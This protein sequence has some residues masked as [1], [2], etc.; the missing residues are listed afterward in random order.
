LKEDRLIENYSDH[1][2]DAN[3]LMNFVP[4]RPISEITKEYVESLWSLYEPRRYLKRCLDQ[5]LNIS[6][7]K[8]KP[9]KQ[10]KFAITPSF[11]LEI[12]QFFSLEKGIKFFIRLAW[13]QGICR[14]EI[15][16]QFWSQLGTI[17]VKKP[18][19]F[20]IYLGLCAAG[21]HFWE[22]R[23]VTR[24]RIAEQLGHDP[25]D[26]PINQPPEKQQLRQSFS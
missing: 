15:R 17:L 25:L 14:P 9:E 4:T 5:C 13:H 1:T 23:I 6:N 26:S 11:F 16:S 19:M 10:K 12:T 22:Y 20:G 3:T 8:Q 18:Q 21:E 2:G 7:F 24:E